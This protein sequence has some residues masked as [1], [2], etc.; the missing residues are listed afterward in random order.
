MKL[1]PTGLLVSLAGATSE[2][3]IFS[4]PEINPESKKYVDPRFTKPLLDVAET[5]TK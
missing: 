5:L 2:L 4:N 3:Y 1:K